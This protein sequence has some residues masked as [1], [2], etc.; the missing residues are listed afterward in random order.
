[1]PD[2]VTELVQQTHMVDLDAGKVGG[3]V[4]DAEIRRRDGGENSTQTLRRTSQVAIPGMAARP[5]FDGDVDPH[6]LSMLDDLRVDPLEDLEGLG[7]TLRGVVRT[8]D[9]EERVTAVLGDGRQVLL[10]VAERLAALGLVLRQQPTGTRVAGADGQAETLAGPGDLCRQRRC[11]DGVE[12]ALGEPFA[13]ALETD[14]A[15]KT[16]HTGADLHEFILSFIW[17]EQRPPPAF[18]PRPVGPTGKR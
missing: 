14:V 18:E 16:R 1:M 3:V 10:Q 7:P 12:A 15:G 2:A 6:L 8:E 9:G 17:W 4:A 11:V 5:G 13:V